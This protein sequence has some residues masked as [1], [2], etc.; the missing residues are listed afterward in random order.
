M[1]VGFLVYL[2][3]FGFII[4]RA[5]Q[6]DKKRRTRF[7]ERQNA[8]GEGQARVASDGHVIPAKDDIS[9]A[10]FGH[11]HE[12]KQDPLFPEAQFIVHNEP[13]E[14]YIN[15]NGKLL[16]RSEADEYMRRHG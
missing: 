9:C 4:Y 3:L 13:A 1:A 10:K 6:A 7:T 12:K 5:L 2:F 8:A 14:G 15:L 11:H 16:R